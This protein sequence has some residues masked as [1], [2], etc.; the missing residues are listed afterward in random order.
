MTTPANYRG[1][2]LLTSSGNI[3]QFTSVSANMIFEDTSINDG[4]T[5]LTANAIAA[6]FDPNGKSEILSM[7]II[8]EDYPVEITN[9]FGNVYRLKFEET[10][11]DVFMPN[12]DHTAYLIIN[13]SASLQKV[14]A[15]NHLLFPLTK[16]TGTDTVIITG[17]ASSCAVTQQ[18]VLLWR[19]G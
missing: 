7:T 4:T 18:T 19:I 12:D 13:S 14:T 9:I 10:D 2:I 5:T 3:L 15:K 16:K 8:T 6:A 17:Q 1:G 11:K